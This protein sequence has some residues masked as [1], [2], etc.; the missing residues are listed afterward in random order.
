MGFWE[1][2]I[3]ILVIVFAAIAVTYFLFKSSQNTKEQNAKTVKGYE[4]EASARRILGKT[5]P[6]QQYVINRLILKSGDKST[7]EIDHLLINSNGVFVIETK[8]W[9]GTIYGKETDKYWTQVLTKNKK[10]TPENPI[11]QNE[12]HI[13]HISNILSEKLPIFS[14]IV[15]VQGNTQKID[16]PYVYTLGGLKKLISR[17]NN[18]I[19]PKQMEKAYDE[20]CRANNTAVSR[21][22]HIKNI[23]TM[24]K[25]ID[26][27]CP[28]CGK[29]LVERNGKNGAFI[30]CS[31]YPRCRFTKNK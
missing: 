9:S 22:E 12:T 27:T 14:V 25:N 28:R 17:E 5:I 16:A 21:K 29:R 23:N 15:F 3:I 10:N 24:L 30:G 20:L 6:G 19:T 1:Y 2:L 11:K 18:N 8:N 4:G 31:G 13:F 7:H 26:T